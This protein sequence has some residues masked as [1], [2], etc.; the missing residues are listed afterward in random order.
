MQTIHGWRY[1]RSGVRGF[2]LIELMIVVAIIG[3]LA[4]VAIPAFMKYIRRSKTVEAMNNIGKMYQSSVAYYESEHAGLN[5]QILD[6]QFPASQAATPAIGSCCGQ[7]G[8]KCD[9]ALT[10]ASWQTPTWASLNFSV[11]DPFYYAY[12]YDSS[13]V[14]ATSVFSAWA[15]GDLDCDTVYSTFMRGGHID[16]KNNVTGGAGLFT[17]LEI[18]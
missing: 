14:N 15:F 2:T 3:I 13:G 6:R 18:E 1:R 16:A 17:K 10:V 8:D 9:P 5:Q 7:K 12:K 4:A 11:D